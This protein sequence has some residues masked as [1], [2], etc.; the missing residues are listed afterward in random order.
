[1]DIAKIFIGVSSCLLG[2]PVRFDGSHKHNRYIT[3]R[4]GRY[5]QF[6]PIC[7]EVAI[8]L[9]VP[10]RPIRLVNTN[11]EIRVRGID[12]PAH[13]V[14][15]ALADYSESVATE[16]RDIS[17]YI[18][19][20]KSPSCGMEQVRVYSENSAQLEYSSGVFASGIMR[21]YPSLPVEDENRLT[22]SNVRENFVERV[23]VYARW[24]RCMGKEPEM[25]RLIDFHMR[26]K[27]T[28]LAHDESIYR[29]L[30]RL[31]ARAGHADLVTACDLYLSL[32]MRALRKIPTKNTHSNVL[33][34]LMGF[35]KD[36]LD[37]GSKTIMLDAINDYRHGQVPLNVPVR[38]IRGYLR[39]HPNEYIS[40][41]YYLNPGPSELL[42][43]DQI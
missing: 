7:P 29:E 38:L 5:F 43:R 13:D 3:D 30:G 9:A 20:S 23:F 17:G 14:T 10:R 40:S 39:L 24:Q 41:Q 1:M 12:D 2:E 16:F 4:L 25:S 42:Y 35:I 28:I 27:F 15:E 31:V 34:H 32:L 19:K 26:H 6:R 11:G 21:Q 8:G 37:V 36:H 33:Q 22:D 18:F